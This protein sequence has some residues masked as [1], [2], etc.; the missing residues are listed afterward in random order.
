MEDNLVMPSSAVTRIHNK[1]LL[2][3]AQQ[4]VNQAFDD[5]RVEKHIQEQSVYLEDVLGFLDTC[6]RTL[7]SMSNSTIKLVRIDQAIMPD[8]EHEC[9]VAYTISIEAENG[10]K[11][12]F[13]T[14]YKLEV[15][16]G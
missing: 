1:R 7:V 5:W 16:R 4:T 12:S 8:L 6:C 15:S 2:I 14:H 10:F 3:L 9:D 13:T 11:G